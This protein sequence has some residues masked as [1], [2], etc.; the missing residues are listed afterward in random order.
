VDTD[1]MVCAGQ[2]PLDAQEL[3]SLILISDS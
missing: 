1:V 2:S 3:Y